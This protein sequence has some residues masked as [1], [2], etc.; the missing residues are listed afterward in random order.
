MSYKEYASKEYVDAGLE[1]IGVHKIDTWSNWHTANPVLRK[2]EIAITTSDGIPDKIYIGDG[3]TDFRHLNPIT[4]GIDPYPLQW[5]IGMRRNSKSGDAGFIQVG[6]Q[7]YTETVINKPCMIIWDGEPID[8]FNASGDS[9]STTYVA[10]P[11]RA[12]T[13]HEA[14]IYF[15]PN[16]PEGATV[17]SQT[18]N[19][20]IGMSNA[21][22]D[23]WTTSEY[24]YCL[25][26]WT[27]A[28]DCSL[29]LSTTGQVITQANF[30]TPE[31]GLQTLFVSVTIKVQTTT[32]QELRIFGGDVTTTFTT[33][34]RYYPLIMDGEPIYATREFVYD[35]AHK[36]AENSSSIEIVR[37]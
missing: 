2:G 36:V 23:V 28:G 17:S 25:S 3:V 29:P 37:W 18:L 21:S 14:I 20:K 35:V 10:L 32:E 1:N 5:H 7:E 27:S 26:D 4:Y 31:D 8:M 6:K 15:F 24:N 13:A 16:A 11:T 22:S 12:N 9:N 30:S 34:N 33:K 19:F